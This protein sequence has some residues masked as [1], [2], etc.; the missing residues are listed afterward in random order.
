M[1]T[2]RTADFY[3]MSDR[4]RLLPGYLADINVIDFENLRLAAP[5]WAAD[6][7]AGGRRLLQDAHG[8]DCTIKSGTPTWLNGEPTKALPG[9]LVRGRRSAGTV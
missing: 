8:Y 6:L 3:G 2:S 9:T 1:Q 4:G 7:P 5:Y